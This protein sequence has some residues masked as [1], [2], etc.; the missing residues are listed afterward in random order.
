MM[1]QYALNHSQYLDAAKYY[2][3]VWE[4]PTI[5]AEETGRGKEVSSQLCAC[6]LTTIY[7]RYFD[8]HLN[9]SC[10]MSFSH[11]TTT[12]SRICCIV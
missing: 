9:I 6:V 3:K 8:R 1:I 2:H 5:K 10:T 4:T 11:L 12:S 7:I